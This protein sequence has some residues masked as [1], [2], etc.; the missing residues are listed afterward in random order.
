MM[1]EGEAKKKLLAEQ[2]PLIDR[3]IKK[4]Q[5]TKITTNG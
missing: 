1:D 2:V 5:D 3:L 4:L